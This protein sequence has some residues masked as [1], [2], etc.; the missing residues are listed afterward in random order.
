MK[1]WGFTLNKSVLSTVLV[2]SVTLLAACTSGMPGQQER[3]P[4]YEQVFVPSALTQGRVICSALDP[5]NASTVPGCSSVG[6]VS[7]QEYMSQKGEV[8]SIAYSEGSV[9]CGLLRSE[10]HQPRIVPECF[11]WQKLPAS[12]EQAQTLRTRSASLSSPSEPESV[13][14]GSQT[15][16]TGTSVTIERDEDVETVTS[17]ATAGN[18]SASVTRVTDN[19][20]GNHRTVFN[21]GTAN[22]WT[23]EYDAQT[24][25]TTRV[26]DGK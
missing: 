1:N 22:E 17:Q 23:A 12:S 4:G 24:G 21:E 14:I 8:F 18:L 25:R 6:M 2:G 7:N 5:R 10:Y 9:A 3:R 19:S 20:T 26:E 13:D 15:G 11:I 16:S